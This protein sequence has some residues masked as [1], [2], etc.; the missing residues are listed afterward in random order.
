MKPPST[1]PNRVDSST[2]AKFIEGGE[3]LVLVKLIGVGNTAPYDFRDKGTRSYIFRFDPALEGH[4][5]RIPLHLWQENRA[6]L[7]HDIM[8]QRHMAHSMV[9]TLEQPS[10]PAP[11]VSPIPQSTISAQTG[12]TD[13]RTD[14]RIVVGPG[15]EPT[16]APTSP[17]GEKAVDE[18]SAT[19][20]APSSAK[21]LDGMPDGLPELQTADGR[22]LHEAA[23]DLAEPPK[24][25]KAMAALL[26]VAEAS[27]RAAI[28]HPR[29]RVELAMAGWVRRKSIA[30]S[31]P[32]IAPAPT[33]SP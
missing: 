28:D 11:P 18:T 26:G 23:Y 15:A 21:A 22:P 2:L 13:T 8:D 32:K 33:S 9:V 5:L 14:T 27:V 1:L 10:T 7:A 4:V 16:V 3:P 19:V 29:S 6:R 30:P 20:V 17:P 12:A 24:R 31:A 25:L